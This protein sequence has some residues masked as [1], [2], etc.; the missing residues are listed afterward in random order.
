MNT[1]EYYFLPSNKLPM[2]N[3]TDVVGKEEN[4][5]WNKNK[6]E[7]VIKTKEGIKNG[8]ALTPH[9]V[10]NQEEAITYMNDPINGFIEVE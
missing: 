6:T 8:G 10:Y 3:N 2:A 9:Q 1:N 5:V 4:I 7:F